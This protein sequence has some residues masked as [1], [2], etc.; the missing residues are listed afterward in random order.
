[1]I[2]KAILSTLLL[3]VFV[4]QIQAIEFSSYDDLDG[5]VFSYPGPNCF[6]VAMIG[7]G[8]ISQIRSVD[9]T[10]F[11]EFLKS[12]CIEVKTP[13][14]GDIGVFFSPDKKTLIHSYLYISEDLV[15]E[16][17]GVDYV[18]QTPI[19]IRNPT[20]TF[21]IFEA[22]PLCKRYSPPG[23]RDCYNVHRYFACPKN[24]L[25][26]NLPEKIKALMES[27]EI[28]F[29]NVLTGARDL[30]AGN[31]SILETE[32]DNYKALV[33]SESNLS[34][35]QKNYLLSI[36]VSYEKQ[37]FFLKSRLF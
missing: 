27:I 20:H 34:K 10:E 16:K 9:V 5:K 18:G 7:T 28:Y 15:M 14:K 32:I 12:S 4:T 8:H 31:M 25:R 3:L 33:N 21:S 11:H 19:Y 6:A 22:D 17:T 35:D 2:R 1:M 24:N 29:D 23:N 30:T 13:Q 36:H 37:F 26:S